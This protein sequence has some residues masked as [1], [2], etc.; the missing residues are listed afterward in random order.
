MGRWL[1]ERFDPALLRA[2]R[3]LRAGWHGLGPGLV[4][5]VADD[6]PSGISTYTIASAQHG[7]RLL[8]ASLLTLPMNIIDV[9][10]NNAGTPGPTAFMQQVSAEDFTRVLLVNVLGTFLC[11]KAVAPGMIERR[12]GRIINLS[13]AGGGGGVIRGSAPY[14]TSKGA[15]EAFTRTAAAE[16]ARFDVLCVAL[17][18]GRVE[19]RGFPLR[20]GATEQ[21]RTAVV[22]PALAARTALWLANEAGPDVGGQVVHAID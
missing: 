18:S 5:G 3:R 2:S 10:V 7:Y 9:L 1:R 14:G 17:Q 15:V 22:P 21:E 11:A 4:T 13:G 12:S 8:W 19:T 16:L 20:A 6:D